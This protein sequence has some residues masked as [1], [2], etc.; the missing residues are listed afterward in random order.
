M[1]KTTKRMKED[2]IEEGD[3]GRQSEKSV[4]LEL[5]GT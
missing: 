4:E 3:T 2:E 1:D 5:S